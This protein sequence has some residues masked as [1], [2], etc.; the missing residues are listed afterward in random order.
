ML[1]DLGIP[2]IDADIASRKVVE[3]GMPALDE[4]VQAFG[5]V[6]QREGQLDR[7]KLGFI[8]FQ[9]ESKRKQLN[10]I[11]HPRVREWMQA[12]LAIY[13]KKAVPA[14][15]LDIPLLIESQLTDWCDKVLLVYV[16]AQ[17][18][19]Q[20][21]MARDHLK[22]ED[23]RL[24]IQAQMPLEDKRAYAERIINNEG[25]ILETREQLLHIL[26][27]WHVPFSIH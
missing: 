25:S 26:Q 7:K 23:A 11:V 21:L 22:E 24:R 9:D 1:F 19:L 10:A 12:Q 13:E 2:V 20:R 5:D 4:I 16:S 6:L 3:P 14:V 8:I 15:V 18:Q 27:E 17:T